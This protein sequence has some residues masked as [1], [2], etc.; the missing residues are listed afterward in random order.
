MDIKFINQPK[1]L[2]MGDIL[3]KK[4]EERFD[5]AWIISGIVKDSGIEYL[6]ESIEKGISN[7][8]KVHMLIGVDRK[9]TSKDILLKLLSVGVDLNIHVN[10]EEDKVETRVYV[11]ES[12]TNDSYVYLC[13]GKLSEGGLLENICLITEIKYSKEDKD[14]FKIFK[15]QLLQ[16]TA[17]NFKTIDRE[18]IILLAKNGEILSRIIDRKIPSISELYGNKEQSIGEQVYDEGANLGLF[19]VED[20][21]NVDIEFD[22][23][24]ELRKNVELEVE[25]EAKKDILETTKTEKDLKRLL[26]KDDDVQEN[27]NKKTKIIKDV[28]E[29]NSENVTTLIFEAGKIAK[30]GTDEGKIKL[31]KSL[32]TLVEKFLDVSENEDKDVEVEILDNKNGEKY[33]DIARFIN[34]G[35]GISI[36]SKVIEGLALDEIDIVRI[37]KNDE[38]KYSIE[39]IRKDTTEYAIW[40]RYCVNNL[41]GTS[42]RYGII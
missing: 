25:K 32:A 28:K 5:D 9:N 40:A 15:N 38:T 22:D 37:L 34:N 23:G 11:F 8:T 12:N 2:K 17:N 10:Q 7:G 19:N 31:P 18:D 24:I 3:R 6:I 1:E 41:K 29:I 16:G 33:N 30:T 14:S 4:L 36:Y 39:I 27:E 42:R 13:S 20:L 21:D 35:K 26:G